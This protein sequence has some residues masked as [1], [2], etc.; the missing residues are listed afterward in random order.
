MPFVEAYRQAGRAVWEQD[1]ALSRTEADSLRRFVEWNAREENKYYRYDYY[2][3][4]CA[5]RLRDAIDRVLGGALKESLAGTADG[6][7]YR[8]ETLRLASAYPVI[9]FGMDFVLGRRADATLSSWEEMFIPMR[10]RDILG[11]TTIRRKDGTLA[12][13]IQ[14]QRVLVDDRRYAERFD[15]PSYVKPAAIA[16]ATIAAIAILLALLAAKSRAARLAFASLAT[17]WHLFAGVLGAILISAGLFTR[18]VYMAA[19]VNVLIATPVSLALAVLIP[20]AMRRG[21]RGKTGRASVQLS[22]LAAASAVVAVLLHY[23]PSL[24]Q[25]NAAILLIAVPAHCAVA[26]GLTWI[27]APGARSARSAA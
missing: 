25:Q 2:R 18:H 17:A 7:S 20:I 15:A 21:L 10:V 1:L 6:F 9:N 4:D 5:T 8:T 3:D 13:L 26:F 27:A 19:N 22:L 23:V 24:V 14:S 12:R 16:G 11:Q